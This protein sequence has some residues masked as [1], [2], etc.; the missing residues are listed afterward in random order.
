MSCTCTKRFI[1]ESGTGNA[2]FDRQCLTESPPNFRR[3][4]VTG[5]DSKSR[6]TFGWLGFSD[7]I[8]NSIFS[9]FEGDPWERPPLNYAL[10]PHILSLRWHSD[11]KYAP[12][13]LRGNTD[14]TVGGSY[15]VIP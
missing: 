9:R 3:T 10:V 12:S 8:C 11:D 15:T 7:S 6:R 13:F 5:I 4:F 14:F 2:N 1:G